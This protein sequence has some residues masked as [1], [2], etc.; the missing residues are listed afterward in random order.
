MSSNKY[1]TTN[2]IG[3]FR[4]LKTILDPYVKNTSIFFN[5]PI[6]DYSIFGQATIPKISMVHNYQT[7]LIHETKGNLEP[8]REDV[9]SFTAMF[10]DIDVIPFYLC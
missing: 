2:S 3:V 9:F 7:M 4:Q 10:D 8:T 1:I 6:V 5:A